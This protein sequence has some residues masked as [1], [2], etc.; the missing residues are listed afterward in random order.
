METKRILINKS[1]SGFGMSKEAHEMYLKMT[2]S[3][4]YVHT[5]NFKKLFL[6]SQPLNYVAALRNSKGAS[7]V[8]KVNAEYVYQL[9][10]IIRDHPALFEIADILGVENMNDRFSNLEFV[11]VETNAMWK[12]KEINGIE[13][14]TINYFNENKT[15]STENAKSLSDIQKISC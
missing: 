2:N 14:I 4:Y 7:E 10:E 6:K 3:R 9:N 15:G 5:A 11:E 12:I 1:N 8:A 13:Y